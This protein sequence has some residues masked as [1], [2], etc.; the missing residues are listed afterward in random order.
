MKKILYL[1]AFIVLLIGCSTTRRTVVID[2]ITETHYI[3]STRWHDSTIYYTIPIERYRDYTS[4][5]D[6]LHIETTMASAQAYVDTTTNTLKGSIENKQDSLKTVVKWKERII[7][8]DSLVYQ[9]VPVE[10][11]VEVTKYP[12]SYWWFMGFTLLAGIYFGL[13]V[14][15]K[16]LN[17]G[18][19]IKFYL[20]L[21]K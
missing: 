18:F 3:D 17:H 6:T 1:L 21:C 2:H 16:V 12:K 10:V 20:N 8:K 5:L 15:L 7:Q 4:L 19:N 14:F 9:E 13:K 11:P